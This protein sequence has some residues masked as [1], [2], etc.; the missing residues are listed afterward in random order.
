MSNPLIN[1][2]G[3]NLFWYKFWF[4]DKNYYLN[5]QQDVLVSK[6]IYLFL[7]YGILLPKNIF[8]SNFWFKNKSPSANYAIQHNTK[9]YR[10]MSYKDNI[11]GA[12][13]FYFNR[14]KIK[15]IY[16]GKLWILR[17]QTWLV[18]NLYCFKPV[19]SKFSKTT[20]R[21]HSRNNTICLKNR[22]SRPFNAAKRLFFFLFIK[23][24]QNPNRHYFF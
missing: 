8:T 7:N 23:V 20:V 21:S 11:T 4:S 12:V 15:N 6:L 17:Y 2:W 13:S 10:V 3:M 1:R 19:A 9:Y 5:I 24:Y 16:F 22:D 18:V 14:T